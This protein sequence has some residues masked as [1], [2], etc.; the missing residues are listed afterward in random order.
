MKKTAAIAAV[1]AALAFVP[2]A[3][4]SGSGGDVRHFKGKP[5]ATLPDAVRNLSESNARLERLLKGPVDDVAIAEIHQLT[6]TMENG[7]EKLRKELDTLAET[8]EHLHKASEKME[9][10]KVLRHGADYLSVS[11]QV[12]K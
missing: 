9:R 2:A 1:A 11:R 4:A 6:Y 12:I 5:S 7:L 8:L 3:Q 10:E